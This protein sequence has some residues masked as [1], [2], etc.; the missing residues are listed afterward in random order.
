MQEFDICPYCRGRNFILAQQTTDGT[1]TCQEITTLEP[2]RLYH[3]V[4]LN[5][6]TIVRT[7][8]EDPGVLLT[9]EKSPRQ[10]RLMKKGGNE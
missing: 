6:G 9:T 8:V 10:I 4:C 2:G 5:C 3:L 7:F 1:L